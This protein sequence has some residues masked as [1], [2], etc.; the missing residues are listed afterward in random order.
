MLNQQQP[1]NN[2]WTAFWFN[3][4][5]LQMWAL[6]RACMCHGV[7]AWKQRVRGRFWENVW[8]SQLRLGVFNWWRCLHPW[9]GDCLFKPFKRKRWIVFCCE[10]K[11]FSSCPQEQ[12]A[13]TW[14]SSV[15]IC[16]PRWFGHARLVTRFQTPRLQRL[17]YHH[18]P[19]EK[20]LVHK[21]SNYL[22]KRVR[23]GCAFCIGTV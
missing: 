15:G 5:I 10:Q 4:W 18:F 2:C 23:H 21:R 1:S 9:C 22:D 14:S 8:Q 16:W 13:S 17:M 3:G 7:R 20:G 11:L 12:S 6:A 19:F